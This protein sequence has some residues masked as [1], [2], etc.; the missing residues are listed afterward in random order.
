MCCL[1]AGFSNRA[2]SP[3]LLNCSSRQYISSSC[4]SQWWQPE[5]QQQRQLQHIAGPVRGQHGL[6]PL[7]QG[8]ASY[9]TQCQTHLRLSEPHRQAAEVQ[10]TQL[11]HISCS[12][13]Q[14]GRSDSGMSVYTPTCSRGPLPQHPTLPYGSTSQARPGGRSTG[15]CLLLKATTAPQQGNRP[16]SGQHPTSHAP[17]AHS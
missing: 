14:P 13:C 16:M 1:L 3:A 12:R 10:Q 4:C 6:H 5:R 2:A 7:G 11:T 9:S 8:E 17:A 15:L